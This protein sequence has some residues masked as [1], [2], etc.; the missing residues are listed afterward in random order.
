MPHF[1]YRGR[2]SRGDLVAGRLEAADSGQVADQLLATGITPVEIG[3]AAGAEPG[4]GA[5]QWCGTP[6]P[7]AA[8]ALPDGSGPTDAAGSFPHIPYYAI[9][10]TLQDIQSRSHGR[11]RV[12]VNGL[13]VV[14]SAPA[15]SAIEVM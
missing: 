9:G 12:A 8:A 5:P 6:G 3:A 2:N 7:D 4:A 13:V 1:S 10:C 15:A 14:V 11:M